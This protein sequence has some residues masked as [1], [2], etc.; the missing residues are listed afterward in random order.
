VRLADELFAVLREP[1]LSIQTGKWNWIRDS[2][3][4]IKFGAQRERASRIRRILLGEDASP[5]STS[6]SWDFS[7]DEEDS[8]ATDEEASETLSEAYVLDDISRQLGFVLAELQQH[9]NL[10]IDQHEQHKNS[11]KAQ[12][13]QLQSLV[14]KHAAHQSASAVGHQQL[15]RTLVG[16]VRALHQEL[17]LRDATSGASQQSSIEEQ[18]ASLEKLQR[19]HIAMTQACFQWTFGILIVIS[20]LII[21]PIL[22]NFAWGLLWSLWCLFTWAMFLL[23]LPFGLVA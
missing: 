4:P 23:E 8:E 2:Y 11:A 3:P 13:S 7:D 18:L 17:Q 14:A 10:M 21:I 1:C 19:Q 22:V 20:L 9:R 15:I 5:Y 6:S 16:E 12:H